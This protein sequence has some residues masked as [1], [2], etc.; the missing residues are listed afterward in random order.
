[1]KRKNLPFWFATP[2]LAIALHAAVPGDFIP[3]ESFKGSSLGAWKPVGGASWKAASGTIT[4]NAARGDGWLES[5]KGF[6]DIMLFGQFRCTGECKAGVLLR[7]HKNADAG[8]TGVYVSLSSGDLAAYRLTIDSQGKEVN[9]EKL[10]QSGGEGRG[11]AGRGGP[12]GAGAPAGRGRGGQPAA[13]RAVGEWNT[14]EV[15]L[16][17]DSLRPTLNGGAISAGAVGDSGEGFGP[18]LLHAGGDVEFRDLAWKDLNAQTTPVEI[19]SSHFTKNRIND[20]YFGYSVAVADINHDGIP[21]IVSGPFYYPGPDFTVRHRYRAGRAYNNSVEFAPDMVNYAA[22][23][24]GDGWPDILASGMDDPTPGNRP[25]TLYV[26]PKGE[27]RQWNGYRVVPKI[28]TELVLMKDLFGD[29]KQEVIYGADGT[30][31][32]AAPDPADPT[33]PWVGHPISEN[34][35]RVNNHGMGVG[36]NN[37]DGRLDLVTPGGW[38][39]QPPKGSQQ[40]WAF[41]AA[42]FGGGGGEIGVYD[43]NGD[44]LADVVTSLAAHGFGLAW[45]EQKR[46]TSGAIAFVEHPIAGDYSADNAG[47]VTFSQAHA[48]QF[49]D[50]DGDGI[51]DM[52]VGKSFYHHLEMYGD[53]D[54][55]GAPVL[56]VY[57][58][59][60]KP[61][62]PGGAEFVP[63]LINNRSGVGSQFAV[64]DLNHDGAQDV[65]VQDGLGTFIFFG[66]PGSWATTTGKH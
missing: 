31:Q 65:I 54:L 64:A 66:K 34:L 7:A 41:H 37:G 24:N 48:A 20:F 9:R 1:M 39:E 43:V 5:G 50:I 11:G 55:Y 44:G 60:R 28:S 4:A 63:E 2:A 49:T 26:N 32:W 61:S 18:V 10:A 15:L 59:V 29:G 42:S 62:A 3:D 57:R 8:I 56:Y 51:K 14:I 36:D 40:T 13:L 30:Y 22:D 52:I 46:D 27:S 23:F 21:D 45:F 58:V 35:G 25:M 19:T 17:A 47:G 6:Q 53:A 16:A 33:K 12:P 38:F